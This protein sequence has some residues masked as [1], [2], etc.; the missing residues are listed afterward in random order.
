MRKITQLFIAI[1]FTGFG[2]T[3]IDFEPEGVGMDWNWTVDANGSNAPLEFVSNPN[4]TAVNSTDVTAKFTASPNGQPWALTYTDAAGSINFTESNSLVKMSV[5]KTVATTVAIKF[6]DSTNPSFFKQIEVANTV[7]NGDWEELSFDFSTVIGNSYDRMVII[8]DLLAR[9]E[10][11]LLYFDQIS[12]NSGGAVED[13][14]LEDIDFEVDGFGANWVWTVHNNHSNPALEI[15]PNPNLSSSNSSENVAK[16]TSKADGEAWALTFT[17]NIGTFLFNQYN[18]IV[19]LKVR[20]E[21]ASN[22]GVKFEYVDPTNAQVLYFKELQLPTTVT[23]GNWEALHFDFS[24]EIG[25]AYNRLVIIPDFESRSQDNISYFD[26]VSFSSVAGFQNIFLNRL[27]LVPN[28]ANN[29]VQISGD[30]DAI[31]AVEIFDIQGKLVK[32]IV[33]FQGQINISDLKAGLYFVQITAANKTAAKKL[34][35]Y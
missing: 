7:T 9:S 18:K 8:P 23:D 16:F 4:P 11:H 20:K 29:W 30:F 5:L 2:Q 24:S 26:Q 12:F 35:V 33:S 15:V 25:T 31:T 10:P 34:V 21:V 3:T 28:P 1:S 27:K 22:F 19:S 13:Y 14:N 17:D 32:E 6:E